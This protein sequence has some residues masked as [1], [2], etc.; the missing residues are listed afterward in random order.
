MGRRQRSDAVMSDYVRERLAR[1]VAEVRPPVGAAGGDA[2]KTVVRRPAEP[3]AAAV[4]A[5]AAAPVEPPVADSKVGMPS[6]P[7]SGRRF[8]RNHLIVL[9]GLLL[10]GVLVAGYALT[11]ARAIPLTEPLPVQQSGAAAPSSP[12]PGS[13]HPATPTA[14]PSAA[15]VRVHVVGEVHRPGV[16]TLPGGARVIE[17]IT[18]AGG[19]TAS[20]RPGDLNLA[21][22]LTDGQQVVVGNAA[23]PGGEVR[24]GDTAPGASNGPGGAKAPG[25]KLNLNSATVEQLDALPGVGPVTAQKILAWRTQHGRFNR[26]EELQEVPGIGPK[27]FAD[28]APL[29]TV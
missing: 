27:S 14:T 11:R 12:G 5:P 2:E 29:V 19:F 17:A 20:A 22:V 28:I 6:Q 26:I 9:A 7:A 3:R 21:Q 24:G 15:T 13:P 18:A 1:L 4:A 16:H 10:V 8:T 23:R 25:G